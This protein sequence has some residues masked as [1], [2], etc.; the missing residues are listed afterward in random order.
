[1]I[2]QL[3]MSN[4]IGQWRVQ[5]SE[6]SHFCDFDVY[7]PLSNSCGIKSHPCTYAFYLSLSIPFQLSWH[8]F[9]N[10][11]TLRANRK[12]VTA[13]LVWQIIGE[14]A[15]C[16]L[17]ALS[18]KSWI[19]YFHCMETDTCTDHGEAMSH[20]LLQQYC[21]YDKII[22]TSRYRQRAWNWTKN[23]ANALDLRRKGNENSHAVTQRLLRIYWYFSSFFHL[24]ELYGW[25]ALKC[26][27]QDNIAA[28][29]LDRFCMTR[30]GE[31]R[32]GEIGW[33]KREKGKSLKQAENT[34]KQE[35]ATF[36]INGPSGNW[37]G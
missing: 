20:L 24:S 22:C 35:I 8:C 28:S 31:L 23:T 37:V 18:R 21:F 34:Q 4:A 1:M 33:K 36:L 9:Q 27:V 14:S 26:T 15:S 6:E 7:L 29:S 5:F 30:C 17:P 2:W 19:L 32:C 12:I 11:S 3:F 25:S 16:L 13:S 10:T